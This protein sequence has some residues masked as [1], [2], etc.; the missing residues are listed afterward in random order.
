MKIA[1]LKKECQLAEKRHVLDHDRQIRQLS[2]LKDGL[3]DA[4]RGEYTICINDCGWLPL[5]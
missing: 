4:R 5:P 1:D 3:S 2:D